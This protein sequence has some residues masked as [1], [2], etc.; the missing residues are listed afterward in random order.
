MMK[1]N[2]IKTASKLLALSA[3][4]Y[5]VSCGTDPQSPG[6]EYMPDMYR[7]PALEPYSGNSNYADSMEARQPA[8]GTIPRGHLPYGI[9]ETTEGY[10]MAGE[11]LKNPLPMTE[12]VVK[13]GKDVYTKFCVQCHGKTGDGDGPTVAAGHPPPPAYAGAALKTLSEGKMFHSITYGKGY[14]GPHASQLNTEEIWTVIR[15]VQTLQDPERAKAMMNG[16]VPVEDE[17]AEGTEDT[18]DTEEV[19]A[20]GEAAEADDAAEGETEMNH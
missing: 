18:E 2:S 13:E 14:M 5:L 19:E 16:E 20:E 17:T 3:C 6:L 4:V 8:V 10:E 7:T 12:E 1:I 15:Y 11:V 9:P